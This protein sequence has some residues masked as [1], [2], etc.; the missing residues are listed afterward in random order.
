MHLHPELL[1]QCI[2]SI[3]MLASLN[4]PQRK[5]VSVEYIR[6][7]FSIP[8]DRI[9]YKYF[10]DN[11]TSSIR[12]VSCVIHTVDNKGCGD[13]DSYMTYQCDSSNRSKS[14]QYY[15]SLEDYNVKYS[16]RTEDVFERDLTYPACLESC[17]LTLPTLYN[18]LAIKNQ[19]LWIE[20]PNIFKREL[21]TWIVNEFSLKNMKDK[22]KAVECGLDKPLGEFTHEE[23]YITALHLCITVYKNE[24]TE[25]LHSRV[26]N[27]FLS[28]VSV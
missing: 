7:R 17:Y 5:H 25:E 21:V 27:E 14:V 2:P 28:I 6:A 26:I 13:F 12:K 8:A 9:A 15:T 18:Y 1:V 3:R 11:Y 4:K 23:L 10:K 19:R 20:F 22:Y 24:T 16:T